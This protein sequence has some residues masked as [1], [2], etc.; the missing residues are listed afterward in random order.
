MRSGQA[1]FASLVV[2]HY[3]RILEHLKPDV[4]HVMARGKIVDTGGAELALR[5]EK[6]GYAKYGGEPSARLS[7]DA[8]GSS[9]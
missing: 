9:S 8:D 3:A 5:L 4:V 1:S 7:L 6:E 2:T